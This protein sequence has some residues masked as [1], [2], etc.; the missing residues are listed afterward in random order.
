MPDKITFSIIWKDE[1]K[2]TTFPKS[3][4][5]RVSGWRTN[6]LKIDKEAPD[7]LSIMKTDEISE[8]ILIINGI[9]LCFSQ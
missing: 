2:P 8:T 1:K 3:R 9:I 7:R 4:V 6:K 5:I